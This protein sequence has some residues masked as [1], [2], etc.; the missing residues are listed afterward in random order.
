MK[1]PNAANAI[2]A[3]DKLSA[4]LLDVDHGRGGSKAKLF[5]SLGYQSE[6]W[7]QLASDIRRFHLVADVVEQKSSPWGERFEIVAPITG[8]ADDTIVFR[9]IWQIDIG[10]DHPRLIT[11]YPE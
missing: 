5:T 8:P 3:E 11:M 9:S 4:Y 6:Q 10:T 7:Q 2:I 1:L